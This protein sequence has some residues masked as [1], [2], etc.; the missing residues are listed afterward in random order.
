MMIRSR[1]FR[2]T[3]DGRFRCFACARGCVMKDG[4]VGFC[5]VRAVKDGTPVLLN[6]GVFDAVHVDPIEKKPL[7]HFNPGSSVLSVGTTGCSWACA[8][9]QNYDLSQ[10][11]KVEG[12]YFSPEELVQLAIRAGAEG[13]AFTYNE[14]TIYIEYAEDVYRLSR[15]QG[16]FL[17]FVTNGF[18]SEEE[19]RTLSRVL[20]A[21]TVDLK[22]NASREFLRKYSAVPD[23]EPIFRTIKYLHSSGVHVE[24]TD[25]V[26]PRVGD[27]LE[28]ARSVARWIRENLGD[29]VP[30]HF[31]RFHPDYK[32]NWLPVTPV[33][34]LE[35]HY[36]V[37]KDEGLK[38]VY[39]GN[40][41]GHP[42]EHTYCP[43]C[44]RPVIKRYGF[45]I[46]E[47]N[48]DDEMRC[49]FC[50]YRLPIKG[51]LHVKGFEDRFFSLLY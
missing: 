27:S 46:I 17:T 19:S 7:V 8:F 42:Y 49:R 51:K 37:A 3:P 40:V 44:G 25:L 32:M 16:L 30:L 1:Y 20:N 12:R 35:D 34:T 28:E 10:R 38:Y 6:Y 48:L 43:S 31:L 23:P 4:Q 45:D 36:R 11:R 41:P 26:V 15:D 39:I 47:W 33:K 29:E 2:E 21:A 9:C 13:I 50:G 22:G 14:P 5:G 24:I 18:A